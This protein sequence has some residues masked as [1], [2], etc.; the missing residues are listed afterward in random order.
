MSQRQNQDHIFE[1]LFS[2]WENYSMTALRIDKKREDLTLPLTKVK[3]VG[4]Y[5]QPPGHG[6]YYNKMSHG[7][8]TTGKKCSRT[9]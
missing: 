3:R 8:K 6:A 5:Q 2:N 1:Q 7:M 9:Y 4:R